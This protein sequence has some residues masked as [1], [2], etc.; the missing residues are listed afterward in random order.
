MEIK[1]ITKKGDKG[2]TDL[3][4]GGRVDKTDARIVANGRIDTF[5]GALGLIHAHLNKKS[6]DQIEIS[7][8]LFIQQKRLT[9]L[10]GEIVVS[11]KQKENYLKSFDHIKEKDI[12]ALDEFSERLLTSAK[13]LG[14]NMSDWKLHGESGQAVAVV[15]FVVKLAR[16][17]E[18]EVLQLEKKGFT[19]RTDIKVYLNRISDFLFILA[20]YL[21][22]FENG[23]K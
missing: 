17:A 13:E 21:E 5:H 8:F 19:V 1:I 2:M 22:Q 15:D 9:F 18:I 7:D 4:L 23:E 14:Y 20:R 3:W 12:A 16:E 11:E 10:M 6:L